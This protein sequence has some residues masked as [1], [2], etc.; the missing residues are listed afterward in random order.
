MPKIKG[1]RLKRKKKSGNKL[2]SDSEESCDDYKKIKISDDKYQ[3]TFSNG[4]F[5]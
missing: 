2:E 3:I 4:D 1:R 5:Y